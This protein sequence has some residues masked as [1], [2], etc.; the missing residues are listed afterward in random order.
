[1]MIRS[2][3][4]LSGLLVAAAM[5]AAPTIAPSPAVAADEVN[6][7]SVAEK[8]AALLARDYVYPETGKRFAEVLREGIRAGRYSAITGDAL[9][10]PIEAD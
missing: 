8:Y 5:A 10:A 9:G 6:G 3:R 7:D 2:S 1:M 4:L